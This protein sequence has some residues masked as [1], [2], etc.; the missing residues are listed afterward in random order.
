MQFKL[1]RTAF[2]I[3]KIEEQDNNVEYWL[4]RTPAERLSAAWYLI[5]QAYNLE[6]RYDHKLDKTHFEMRKHEV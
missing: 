2:Q 3:K 5:C 4:D 1:D 6:Y